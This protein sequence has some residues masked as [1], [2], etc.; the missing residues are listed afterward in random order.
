[1]NHSNKNSSGNFVN[2]KSHKYFH[3]TMQLLH[4]L[5]YIMYI[6][7]TTLEFWVILYKNEFR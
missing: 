4:I 7:I 5:K 6:G 1:M 2:D 3:I